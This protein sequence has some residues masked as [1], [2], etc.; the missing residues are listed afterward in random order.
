M[1]ERSESPPPPYDGEVAEGPWT[2]SSP[3][4]K[5]PKADKPRDGPQHGKLGTRNRLLKAG[6][7]L[8]FA[9]I[10]FSLA[11][12]FLLRAIYGANSFVDQYPTPGN[13]RTIVHSTS[14]SIVG[15]YH[16][17]DLLDLK[18]TSGTIHITVSPEVADK[19]EPAEAAEFVATTSSGNIRANLASLTRIPSREY[20]T[21]VSSTSG[22][23]T[24]TYLMGSTTTF[25]T[26]S[27]STDIVLLAAAYGSDPP[28]IVTSGNSDDQ[29]ITVLHSE[30][31][32]PLQA[33]TLDAWSAGSVTGDI[34]VSGPGVEII[35][36][37]RSH[38]SK[39]VDA[40]KGD[41]DGRIVIN[42]VSGSVRVFVG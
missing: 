5:S 14:D 39:S 24:G 35:K 38:G 34:S 33:L 28:S 42:T 11:A 36:D 40:I 26:T 8:M 21:R 22:S 31:R 16:L 32:T 19:D 37:D 17:L 10:L 30:D 18:T 4:T 7:H 9:V 29:I 13:R 6:M 25:K 12:G 2:N 41:G 15:N 3:S 27:G 23:I 1:T 20:I